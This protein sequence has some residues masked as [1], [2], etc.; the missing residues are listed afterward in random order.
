MKHVKRMLAAALAGTVML[1]AAALGI[2]VSDYYRADELAVTALAP[3]DTVSVHEAGDG[4]T[5]FTPETPQAGF[6]FYPGG[7]VEASAYAP[8][9]RSLAE[10]GVLCVALE[11]PFHLAVLDVNAA[12]GVQERF[13]GV[14]DWY[15]GGH[16]LGGSMAAS[17]VSEHTEDYEGLIL[18]AAY[19]T[20]DLSQTDLETV[21]LYGSEDGV[22]DL[23][24]YKQYRANLPADTVEMVIKG[25]CH[26][27]FGSYGPQEG[28][29]TP[30]IPVE[31]QLAQT[32]AILSD[33]ILD[34]IEGL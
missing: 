19:S 13:A 24:K 27:Y 11:M 31:E 30:T 5:V 21:S 9:L 29:G 14:E 15:I 28:D 25:G 34:A 22:L 4:M 32:I 18:L 16:S 20:A 6:V 1:L 12:D 33:A 2:Y 8:L 10:E 26:A 7:K 17:Y 23:E 3:T